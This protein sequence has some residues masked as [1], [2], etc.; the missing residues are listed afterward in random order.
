MI[1]VPEKCLICGSEYM[2]GHET[3]SSIMREG[4][5]VFYQ[6]GASMSVKILSDGVFQILFKNCQATNREV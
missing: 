5:R 4:L 6:C 3:P 1:K 2:G